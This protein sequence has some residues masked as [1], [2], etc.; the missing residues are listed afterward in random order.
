MGIIKESFDQNRQI[1]GKILPLD[2]PFTVI[3]DAS[4]VCNLKCNYCFRS[5]SNKKNWGY[6]QSL[7]KMDWGTFVTVVEQI[8]EFPNEVKQISLSHHGEPLTNSLLSN[9]VSYIKS[10][11]IK[12]RVS[13]HTNATLLTEDMIRELSQSRIDRVVVS[14]QGL[15]GES[16]KKVCGIAIDYD[17]FYNNLKRL[18]ECKENTQ[19]SIKIANTA[20]SEG[21]EQKFYDMFTPISDRVFIEQI[22]PIW[23]NVNSIGVNTEIQNKYGKKFKQQK[24]CPLLFHTIVV[25]PNGDIY[26]CTQLL[27]KEKLGNINEH[28]LQEYWQSDRRKDLLKKQLELKAPSICSDCAILNNTIYSEADMIDDYRDEIKARLL[29]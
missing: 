24:C 7:N 28:T 17:R 20:L 19:I 1:L 4:E 26:P 23:K 25:L 18:Y 14:L 6:A 3:V 11:G 9:M 16:Y 10:E 27:S 29:K 8:K 13:I 22:V 12:S 21:E 5:D 2:T 15:N